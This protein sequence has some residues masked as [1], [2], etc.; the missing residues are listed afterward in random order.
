MPFTAARAD[1]DRWLN[2]AT[3]KKVLRTVT[4]TRW[5]WIHDRCCYDRSLISMEADYK[6]LRR[7]PPT[8]IFSYLIMHSGGESSARG[9]PAV[10][11]VHH[12]RMSSQQQITGTGFFSK[13]CGYFFSSSPPQAKQGTL[14]LGEELEKPLHLQTSQNSASCPFRQEL[15]FWKALHTWPPGEAPTDSLMLPEA[16]T[17][18]L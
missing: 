18:S 11:N 8:H 14:P 2:E 10:E 1:A 16:P 4:G 12:A 6:C 17:A 7:E 13:L 9:E 3:D 5:R 15:G